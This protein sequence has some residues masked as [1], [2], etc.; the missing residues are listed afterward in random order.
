MAIKKYKSVIKEYQKKY[1]AEIEAEPH[2][3]HNTSELLK[4]FA[5]YNRFNKELSKEEI[6]MAYWIL[7]AA[8]LRSDIKK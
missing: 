2:S 4:K 7:E 6:L 5:T 1:T 3:Y 8:S